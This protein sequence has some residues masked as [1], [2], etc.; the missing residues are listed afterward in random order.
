MESAVAFTVRSSGASMP[1]EAQA[2]LTLQAISGSRTI[3]PRRV[4]AASPPGIDMMRMVKRMSG[5][6]AGATSGF[7]RLIPSDVRRSPFPA[8]MIP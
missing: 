2:S 5:S 7:G 3:T 1:S 8:A 6:L 4:I